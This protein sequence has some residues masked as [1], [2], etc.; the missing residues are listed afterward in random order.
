MASKQ[1]SVNME[2]INETIRSITELVR[3]IATYIQ[4]MEQSAQSSNENSNTVLGR[5]EE[6]F[7][8]SELLNQTVASFKI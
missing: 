5:M 7:H 6:L 2:G 1:M 3:E 8:L 4:K